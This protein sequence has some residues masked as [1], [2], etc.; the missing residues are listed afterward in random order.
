MMDAEDR[1]CPVCG[2]VLHDE[3]RWFNAMPAGS[4]LTC[5]DCNRRFKAVLVLDE[6]SESE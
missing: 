4:R 6:E 2:G 5:G 3:S 1:R